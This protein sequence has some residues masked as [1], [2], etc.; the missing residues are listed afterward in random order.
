MTET[1]KAQRCWAFP[2]EPLQRI[3]LWTFS[4]RVRRS[5]D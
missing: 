4:L 3:E 2:V 5:A 1:E